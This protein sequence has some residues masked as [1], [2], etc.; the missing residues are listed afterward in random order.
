MGSNID[1]LHAGNLAGQRL[2]LS[3]DG[4]IL[5]IVSQESE[6]GL[7]PANGHVCNNKTLPP[8]TEHLRCHAMSVSISPSPYLSLLSTFYPGNDTETDRYL[9]GPHAN[10]KT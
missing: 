4:S 10:D 8:P 9:A 7:P 2:A 5:S 6:Q 3:S 1:G